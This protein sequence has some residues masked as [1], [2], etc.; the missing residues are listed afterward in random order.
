MHRPTTVCSTISKGTGRKPSRS[1]GRLTCQEIMLP[2][3]QP[4]RA[5]DLVQHRLPGLQ[6]QVVR[7]VEAQPAARG[8][9][10]LGRQ[11]L[12][13]ALRGHGH[14]DG[15][16][17]G[18]VREVQRRGASL[19]FLDRSSDR[20]ALVRGRVLLSIL[21]GGR[22]GG[23][24][25]VALCLGMGWP[26]MAQLGGFHVRVG[27]QKSEFCIFCNSSVCDVSSKLDIR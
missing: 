26:W 3:L 14:E 13:A 2:A 5:A 4:V 11:A 25:A 16:R 24:W 9:E 7:V 15:Q 17:H 27:R 21:P 23:R 22:T 1:V 20:G 19:G 6:T 18:A 10:L 12:E 8:L